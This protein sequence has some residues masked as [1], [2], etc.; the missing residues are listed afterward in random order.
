M[1]T[2]HLKGKG[3]E[4][5]FLTPPPFCVPSSVQSSNADVLHRLLDRG[6]DSD[7]ADRG[8]V[9]LHSP[10]CCVWSRCDVGLVCT[11]RDKIRAGLEELRLVQPGGDT[12]MDR[13]FQRVRN[14]REPALLGAGKNGDV[15]GLAATDVSKTLP[16]ASEQIYYATGDSE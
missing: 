14:P 4:V 1:E 6:K 2:S 11:R 9:R 7:G 15:W 10:E 12:Y 5:C 16:Q 13:G 8:Q 3:Q